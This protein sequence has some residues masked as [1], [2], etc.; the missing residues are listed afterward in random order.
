MEDVELRRDFRGFLCRGG[1]A[2]KFVRDARLGDSQI[3]SLAL[4]ADELE[5]SAYRCLAGATAAREWVQNLAAWRGAKRTRYAIRSVGFTVGW[6][7]WLV[8]SVPSDWKLPGFWL[9]LDQCSGLRS[10]CSQPSL[11]SRR[12]AFAQ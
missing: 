12:V 4:D 1:D 3:G 10:M 11:R 2:L 7:F 8:L 9:P 6:L 5:P